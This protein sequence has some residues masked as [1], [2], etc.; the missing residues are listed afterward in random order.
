MLHLASCMYWYACL[1]IWLFM[2]SVC[3]IL[4]EWVQ[5]K[6]IKICSKGYL[7]HW[8]LDTLSTNKSLSIANK[9]TLFFLLRV[10]FEGDNDFHACLKESFPNLKVGLN[11]IWNTDS[12]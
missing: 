5:Q 9:C 7:Y 12:I 2:Y 6:P 10:L 11:K 1:I 3:I 4:G 8:L